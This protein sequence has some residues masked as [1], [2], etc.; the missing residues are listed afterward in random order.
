[1]S[2]QSID[3]VGAHVVGGYR[4]ALP[5]RGTRE[6]LDSYNRSPL[7]QSIARKISFGVASTRWYV[8]DKRT[9]E[10][11]PGHPLTQMVTGGSKAL[12]GLQTTIC[13]ELHLLL[14]GEAFSVMDRNIVGAPVVRW[15]M[16]PTWVLEVPIPGT[17]DLF[18]ISPTNGGH[19]V[20]LPAQD[21]IWQKEVDPLNP[22]E[23]GSG[24]GRALSDELETDERAAQH[25][26]ATLA[27]RAIPE[28]IVSGSKDAPLDDTS[29]ARLKQIWQERFGGPRRAGQAFFSKVPIE[30][31]RMTQTFDEMKLNDL[32]AFEQDAMIY[33]FGISPEVIGKIVNS[34]RATID[35]AD[36]LFTK[37]VVLPRLEVRCATLN[38][39]LAWQ[40]GENVELCF[41]SPVQEDK[42]FKAKVVKENQHAFTIDEVRAMAGE[43]PLPE[44][45]GERFPMPLMTQFGVHEAAPEP[46]EIAAPPA[47]EASHRAQIVKTPDGQDVS[48]AIEEVDDLFFEAA[49]VAAIRGAAAEFGEVVFNELGVGIS[50][51]VF[52]PVVGEAIQSMAASSS[53]L[54]AGST[55]EKLR[56][57]LRQGLEAGESTG[58][59]VKRI[60]EVLGPETSAAR[61]RTISRTEIVRASNFGTTEAHRQAGITEREWL[62]TEDENVRSSHAELDG[63]TRGIDAPFDSPSGAQ[64]MYPGDFGVAAEDI[65]CRCG[66]IAKLPNALTGEQRSK[67]WKFYDRRRS[68]HERLLE[69]QMVSSFARLEHNVIAALR[70]DR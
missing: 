40:Y 57:T 56:A 43:E 15:P 35:G 3:S 37:N 62:A 14:V 65:N 49:L 11:V 66:V 38:D 4:K 24:I 30:T 33:G 29:V 16:P 9:G 45:A 21:V 6:L 61:A 19:I 70:G 32:R 64:A 20:Y 54:I 68:S 23:R 48:D 18:H 63:Q 36:Y 55:R 52:N 60:R 53:K 41:E 58:D 17:S 44:G 27:N 42:D 7:L 28:T 25:I 31:H 46:R 50:F 8:V 2:G 12:S 51:D 67:A 22:Y 39:Q 5:K 1:M 59:L 69:M 13:E 26:S 34:N 47:G 10:E